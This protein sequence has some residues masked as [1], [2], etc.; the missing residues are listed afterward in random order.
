MGVHDR[1]LSRF[2]QRYVAGSTQRDAIDHVQ[3]LNQDGVKGLVNV[4]GEHIAEPDGIRETVREYERLLDALTRHNLEADL[5]VKLTQ[6]GL[7]I[8][9]E[10]CQTTLEHLLDHAAEHDRFVWID[11]ESTDHTAETVDIYTDLADRYDNIGITIQSYLHRSPDDVA[12]VLDHDGVIRLVRGVYDEPADVAYQDPERVN[13]AYRALLE[14]LF[15]DADYFAIATHNEALITD[16]KELI[17][18]HDR[19]AGTFEFQS[20]MGVKDGI[21]R[22]LAAEGY[23]VGEY[24][25][26]GPDWFAYYKRR[27]QERMTYVARSLTP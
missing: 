7:S 21:E 15:A 20:L 19:D 13:A 25:P 17:D 22:D 10:T 23:T 27:M 2:A 6:L 11:M 9:R 4:L 16:A 3:D 8:G 14:Q 18:D 24:V 1:I 5:S 12:T 26:Y